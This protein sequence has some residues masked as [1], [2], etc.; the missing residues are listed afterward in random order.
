MSAI[1]VLGMILATLGPAASA[2][3]R[4]RPNSR[5]SDHDLIPDCW[6]RRNGLVVGRRDHLSDKD[7]DGLLAIQEFRLDAASGGIF[8]P[9]RANVGNSDGDGGFEKFG[10]VD[11]TLDGWEDFDRDGFINTAERAW[12][13]NA[14]SARSRPF[15]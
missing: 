12:R 9:Y 3:V 7:R 13:T 2:A 14:A 8:G 10:W 5:N 1:L 15:P 6:E 4:C 11:P